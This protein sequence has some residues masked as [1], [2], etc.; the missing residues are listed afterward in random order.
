M[1][2][3][4]R[5]LKTI[6]TILVIILIS[7][8]SFMGIFVKDKNRMKNI[9]PDYELGMD[10]KGGRVFNIKPDETVNTKYYDSEGKEVESSS[11]DESK[12]DEYTKEE[13][14]VNSKDSLNDENYEKVKKI[15]EERLNLLSVKE[16]EIRKSSSNGEIYVTIPED[17][18][19]DTIVS[20]MTPRGEFKIIDSEDK[21]VLLTNNDIK[22][23]KVGYGNTTSGTSVFI[24]I[25]FNKEGT[26]ILNEISKEYVATK[27][28]EGNETKKQIELVLDDETQLTT[29]FDEEVKDGLLQLSMGSAN[30]TSSEDLQ[31]YLTQASNF[32]VLLKTDVMPL[33]YKLDTNLY[34]QSEITNDILQKLLIIFLI[35]AAVI[36][37][38]TIIKYK[39][40][41]LLAIINLIGFVATL[42]ITIRYANV[43]VTF[44]GILAV[45][46]SII[47]N[48]IYILNI[49]K[50]DKEGKKE[51]KKI[52]YQFLLIYMPCLIISV[53]FSFFK[54]VQVACFGM[55]MFWALLVMVVY[56][57]LITKALMSN[58]E[59]NK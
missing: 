24:N 19:T 57:F 17:S 38:F 52:S 11:I 14:P 10:F 3:K 41:G 35:V 31:K 28:D 15:V 53:V 51:H 21:R 1:K 7:L 12:K 34:V 54:N 32:A 55:L 16:Y 39:K 4:N 23:V 43:V 6:L 33:T 42:L 5:T 13:T 50:A 58:S 37:I 2:A 26:K 18:N 36:A 22:D 49:I 45:L 59:D 56:S 48:Y 8:I 47:M 9:L 27:D 30:S 20:E 25:Q 46:L 40:Q 44:T 29:Y